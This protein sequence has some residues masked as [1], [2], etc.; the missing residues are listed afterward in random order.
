MHKTYTDAFK[1]QGFVGGDWAYA[2]NTNESSGAPC[3]TTT[4]GAVQEGARRLG[5]YYLGWESIEVCRHPALWEN[6]KNYAPQYADPS[7][8]SC[9]R[10]E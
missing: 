1:L 5:V 10:M 2:I 7:G 8:H 9:I 6:E 4:D 3:G